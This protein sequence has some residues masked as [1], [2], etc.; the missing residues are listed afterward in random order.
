M[1]LIKTEREIEII[2]RAGKILRSVLDELVSAAKPGV[3][4]TALDQ[5]AEKLI[6]AQGG[7]PAFLHYQPHGASHPYPASICTS[8]NDVVVHGVPSPYVLKKGDVVSIDCGVKL[9]G[10]YSDAA[11]TVAVGAVP[12]KLRRLISVT[13]EALERG[14]AAATAGNTIGDIG[15]TIGSFVKA[16]GLHIVKGLTGH[17]VGTSL[18]EEPSVFNEGQSGTGMKLKPGMVLAIEPM[19]AIGTSTVEQLPDE[20]YATIDKSIAAHFEKTIVITEGEAR[21]LT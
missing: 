21:I 8:V 17:G 16:N 18:H 15:H 10:Y 19:V 7:E 14:I 12:A 4:L 13:E 2:A 5:L 3:A 20:S 9:Q 1:A 6:R 11:V